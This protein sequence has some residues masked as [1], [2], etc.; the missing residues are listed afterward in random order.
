M[1]PLIGF[2]FARVHFQK[3]ALRER[4]LPVSQGS[5]VVEQDFDIF[6]FHIEFGRSE[7]GTVS[8]QLLFL[9]VDQSNCSMRGNDR[10]FRT[11]FSAHVLLTSQTPVRRRVA[12]VVCTYVAVND[13]III[14]VVRRRRWIVILRWKGFGG[15]GGS[16]RR[17]RSWG[18]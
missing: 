13:F 5:R 17:R 1:P 2:V 15:D 12:L 3:L 18:I 4:N 9:E 8:G 11:D 7:Q 14:V 10:M 6:L 16:L